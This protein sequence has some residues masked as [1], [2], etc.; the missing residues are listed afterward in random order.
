MQQHHRDIYI[1]LDDYHHIKS[2]AIHNLLEELLALM[3]ANLHLI[4]LSRVNPPLELE[5]LRA[6]S[7]ITEI[8]FAD[9][10]LSYDEADSFVA[11]Q[12]LTIEAKQLQ[13]FYEQSDGW[14]IGL[15][16]LCFGLKKN[17][18]F[19]ATNALQLNK[20]SRFSQYLEAE[21][22]SQLPQ[23]TVDFMVREP[24]VGLQRQPA[25]KD[26]LV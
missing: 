8:N 5:R 22:L 2:P 17:P 11:S 24:W 14:I 9:L 16:L 6:Y 15:Q 19:A 1:T 12:G 21:V 18:N 13:A 25:R 10:R 3:P 20:D 4:I 23:D 7:R 26:R